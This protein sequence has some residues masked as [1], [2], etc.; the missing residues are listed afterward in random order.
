MVPVLAEKNEKEAHLA[1]C[2][3]VLKRLQAKNKS[4][5][6]KEE[7][8]FKELNTLKETLANL[9]DKLTASNITQKVC[10]MSGIVVYTYPNL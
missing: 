6:G 2:K 9:E 7:K 8:D 4:I 1:E 10:Q 3:R 5:R